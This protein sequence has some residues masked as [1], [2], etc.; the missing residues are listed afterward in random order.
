MDIAGLWAAKD[1]WGPLAAG[2]F[3]IALGLVQLVKYRR[4]RRRAERAI[5][6]V[7]DLEAGMTA[8]AGQLPLHPVVVG[9]AWL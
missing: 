3:L 2:G 6:V 9:I 5:G 4:F 7:V 1:F 8:Q